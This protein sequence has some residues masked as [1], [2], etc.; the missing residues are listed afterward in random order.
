MTYD[1]QLINIDGLIRI[2]DAEIEDWV[3]SLNIIPNGAKLRV[4]NCIS[5]KGAKAVLD[6]KKQPVAGLNISEST[7][8]VP[9][10]PHHLFVR[11]ELLNELRRHVVGHIRN[12]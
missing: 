12:S 8:D 3:I 1:E 10:L 11:Y 9:P 4:V 2:L 6:W 5:Q 7:V